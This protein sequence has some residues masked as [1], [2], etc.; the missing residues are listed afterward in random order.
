[1]FCIVINMHWSYHHYIMFPDVF[2]IVINMHW[3]Y[4]HYTTI[5]HQKLSLYVQ[6]KVIILSPINNKYTKNVSWRPSWMS[7]MIGM[8]S[9]T[10]HHCCTSLSLIW[11]WNI[12]HIPLLLT[13]RLKLHV[14]QKYCFIIWVYGGH[15]GFPFHSI[16]I[17]PGVTAL[18]INI[19]WMHHH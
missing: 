1:M 19:Y 16:I 18:A 5:P 13:R 11:T 4:H 10:H 12:H 14:L 8:L 7:K 3:S 17:F 15:L 9:N 6:I 2:A